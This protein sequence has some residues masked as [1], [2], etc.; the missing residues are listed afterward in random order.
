MPTID[1]V[2]LALEN[3]DPTLV[4]G[5]LANTRI[6][7]QPIDGNHL[8]Q[9]LTARGLNGAVVPKTRNELFDFQNACRSVATK[10][11]KNFTGGVRVEVGEVK[12][13]ATECVY[14][15]THATV[16][17]Q[18]RVIDH[19][20]EMRVVYSKSLAVNGNDPIYVE[21]IDPTNTQTMNL[22]E[23]RVRAHFAAHKGKQPGAKVRAIVRDIFRSMDGTRWSSSNSVWF[24]PTEHAQKLG[25]LQG[26]LRSVYP[27]DAGLE[28]DTIPL[29][30]I[31]GVTDIVQDKVAINARSDAEKL[32]QEIGERLAKSG[33]VKQETF[34]RTAEDRRRI[35]D[36]VDRMSAR[37]GE[38]VSLAEETMKLLD[39]Q[40]MEMMA[41]IA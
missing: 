24:V 15:I 38:E 9:E 26:A 3:L 23:Q 41:R 21:I 11:G 18:N 14:Q 1:E 40:L 35:S 16:D 34:V 13:D 36:Y 5:V 22:I 19:A 39:A 20:K 17:K 30:N 29:P 4:A 33:P 37:L 12:S 28:F 27:A 6:P 2:K 10:R 25:A 31:A 7:D 32:L 8:A